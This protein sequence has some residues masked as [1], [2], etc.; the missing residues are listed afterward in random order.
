[1]NSIFF[2]M[3]GIE[4]LDVLTGAS[5][6]GVLYQFAIGIMTYFSLQ[7]RKTYQGIILLS[8]ISVSGLVLNRK[9]FIWCSLCVL[10]VNYV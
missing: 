9:V 8:V 6:F 1:M 4:S 10:M 5:L 3:D 2:K 7:E